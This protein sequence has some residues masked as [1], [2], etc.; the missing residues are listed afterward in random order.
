MTSEIRG[1]YVESSGVSHSRVIVALTLLGGELVR[2]VRFRNPR[3]I[4]DP[5]NAVRVLSEKLVDEIVILD[6]GRA[7]LE[8]GRVAALREIASEASVPIAYG[9]MIRSVE[10][11]QQII[12]G[13]F[14][15]VVINTALHKDPRLAK[16]VAGQF[17]SQ[18]VVGS[19]EYRRQFW[20]G[21]RVFNDRGRRRTQHRPVE[22][23][24][25]LEDAGCGEILLTDIDRDGTMTGYDI[26][27][28][29]EVS[30]AVS[31][32]VIP[33]GGAKT[34][35]HLQ[36][37]HSA[38]ATAVAAGSMFVLHG[39]RRAVLINYPTGLCLGATSNRQ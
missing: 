31:I 5:I 25:R 7:D 24:R 12:R 20:R 35:H 16:Q 38:G 2:T 14:E 37:A 19:I 34:T 26:E 21:V 1:P 22:W 36:L 9:G 3:Y 30:H 23:A 10:D 13:G 6:I 28:I 4:G 11:A 39:A 27:T 8:S 15:K 33:L 18:A 29:S 32:P 17:G